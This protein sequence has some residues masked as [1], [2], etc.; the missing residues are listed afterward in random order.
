MHSKMR[1]MEIWTS[2]QQGGLPMYLPLYLNIYSPLYLHIYPP[3][4]I[5]PT[6]TP[7]SPGGGSEIVNG[8]S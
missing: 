2:G 5:P 4:Y 8:T 1:N 7:I 6:H 3:P